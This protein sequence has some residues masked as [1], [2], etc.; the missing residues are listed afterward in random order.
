M[1]SLVG[2]TIDETPPM[3]IEGVE[4]GEMAVA[5]TTQSINGYLSRT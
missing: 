1:A 5:T 3:A 4:R 2:L